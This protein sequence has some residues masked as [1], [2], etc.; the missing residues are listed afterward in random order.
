M[1]DTDDNGHSNTTQRQIDEQVQAFLSGTPAPHS[2]GAFDVRFRELNVIGAGLGA[3]RAPT[4]ANTALRHLQSINPV[5][6]LSS[7]PV[8][9]RTLLHSFTGT[10]RGGE[11]LLVLG[12]PGSG[13]TTFL[14]T[15]ANMWQEYHAIEGEVLIGSDDAPRMKKDFPGEFGFSSEDDIHFASLSVETTLRFSVNARISKSTPDRSKLVNRTLDSLI[16]LFGLSHVKKTRVG[17]DYKRGVSGGQRHRVT[18]AEAVSTRAGVMCLD[19]PTRGLDSS[20]ALKLMQTMRSYTNQR[21][22]ATVMSVYQA[23]DAM[24]ELFDKVLVI[25][26]GRQIYFGPMAE[27]KDYFKSLG[28]YCDPRTSLTDFLTTMSGDRRSRTVREGFSGPPPPTTPEEFEAVFKRS[29]YWTALTDE[30]STAPQAPRRSGKVGYALPFWQQVY[31]C[32]MRQHRVQLTDRGP[33][34]AEAAGLIVQALMLGT[35]Y[36]NQQA[37]TRGLYTRAAALFFTV[38]VMVLQA[39]AEFGNTFAQRPILLRHEAMMLYRPASYAL[40]QIL[41]DMP[42][43]VAIILYNLPVYFLANFQRDAAKFFTWFFV[44]YCAIMSLGVMFRTIAVFTVSPTRAILPVGL[45]MNVFIIYTGFYVTPPGM[46]VWLGWIRYL[47]PMYYS[48]EGVMVNEI[49][50]SQYRCSQPDTV[51]V[52]ASYNDSRYQTCAVQGF[53][54]GAPFLEGEAYL[55][56]FYGFQSGHLWRNVGIMLGFFLAF[57]VAVM[58]GMEQFKMPAGKLATVFFSGEVEAPRP[59]RDVESQH[60]G[61]S[62]GEKPGEDDDKQDEESRA[63][64]SGASPSRHAEIVRTEKTFAWKDICIDVETPDGTKRLLDNV[65]GYLPPGSMTALMGM[66]GAGKT[67]L[68]NAI[69]QRAK[70]GVLT[71]S[72][73]LDAS[74]IPRSFKRRTGFVHQQDVHLSTSTVREALRLVAYLRQPASTPR[75][76]KDAY[77]DAIIDLLEMRDIAD[78]VIGAPGAGLSLERRKR[79]SIGVELAAKPD[80]L[81]F[82]DEPTSGLDGDS[83]LL[84]VGL[85]RKLADAGLTVLCTIHQPAARLMRDFDGLLLLMP[86]GRTAYFGE[87]GEDCGSV[88][89]YFERHTRRCRPRENPADYFLAESVN[90]DVDWHRLWLESDE[91]ERLRLKLEGNGDGDDGSSSGGGDEEPDRYAGTAWEQLRVVTRRAFTDYW[92]DPDYVLGK[93]QLNLWMGLINSLTYLQ[94]GGSMTDMRSKMFSI[95]VG[96]ITGPV[97]ALA[98]E[99]RFTR[100]RDQFLA[101]EKDSNTYRWVVFVGASVAVELPWAMITGFVYWCLWHYAV[102]FPY[103]AGRAGYAFLLYQLYTLFITGVAQMTAACFPTVQGA[104]MATGFVFLIINT[105]NGPLSPPPLTPRGW[106]WIYNVSPLFYFVDAMA[107]NAVHGQAVVCK[108]EETSVFFTPP[109]GPSSCSEYAADYFGASNSTGYLLDPS[110]T[111]RC[112]YCPFLDGDQYIRQYEFSYSHRADNVG[113]FIGFILFNFTIVFAVTWLFF[114]RKRKA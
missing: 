82:F 26:N 21:G 84:V 28:F 16:D 114:I 72:M 78:A 64:I 62:Y 17:D 67:T 74:P 9:T 95:F 52:G 11:M 4:V 111:G 5:S 50:G 41:A 83:A 51:P 69:S 87:L 93:F 63:N 1:D 70:I 97:I 81:V 105:F 94:L 91:C 37:A 103:G 57:S 86:G 10:V 42:W 99:P 73:F 71:G 6:Y 13:C 31:Q 108:P 27:A 44:L 33:W 65:S 85:M 113:I 56:A 45:L 49:A 40:G 22:A 25:N 24:A 30:T 102:G 96:V 109:D 66:S 88:V 75:A 100:L 39:S 23:S 59:P 29:R 107:S 19:N 112:E 46:K 55:N 12:K 32:S 68:L 14:K 80:V 77:V 90:A 106:R 43:K 54:P 20:T 79:V 36:W 35:L 7:Q 104:Q 92:R 48:F 58:I 110:A 60:S 61:S 38:L 98:V 101:R 89:E 34:I 47:N 18:V 53:E 15:V 76:A 2:A 3:Q 8:A